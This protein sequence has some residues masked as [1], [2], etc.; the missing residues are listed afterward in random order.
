MICKFDTYLWYLILLFEL[1]FEP[2]GRK[3]F[4]V[5]VILARGPFE[6]LILRKP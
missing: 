5:E 1:F 6:L 4:V 3:V 2:S